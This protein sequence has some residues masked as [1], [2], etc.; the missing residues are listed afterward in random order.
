MKTYSRLGQ[1]G[2]LGNQLW[3]V[4]STIGIAKTSGEEPVF[5]DWDYRPYFS[6]PDQFFPD[7]PGPRGHELIYT[8]AD[9]SPLVEHID[10]RAREYLQDY[11][12]WKQYK[13]QI[14]DYFQPSQQALDIL[15]TYDWF[16][17]LPHPI[18]SV[19][20]RRG[21]NANAPNNCHPLRP[22]SYYEEAIDSLRGQFET[23]IVFS[24]D[25][26]WCRRQFGGY[27]IEHTLA[28]FVGSPRKKEHER[29]YLTDPFSDW[30]DLFFMSFCD[31]HIISNST[32]SWWGAFL[33]HDP[34]PIYP[35]PFFGSDLDYIDTSLM[36]PES[37]V[38]HEHGQQY[39]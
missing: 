3:Q 31:R 16:F 14:W 4:A 6:L 25:P 12:L 32:Y 1:C 22:W 13:N 35:T 39:V 30:I 38:P 17:D 21:D 24:D 37:W 10:P 29:G 27:E 33:S 20:I 34:A 19:H 26:E 9:R 36:F 11:G 8:Q 18:L 23:I 7:F 2:R 5:R 28:F 15:Q